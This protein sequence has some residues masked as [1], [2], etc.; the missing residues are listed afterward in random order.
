MREPQTPA[1]PPSSRRSSRTLLPDSVRRTVTD[2]NRRFLW[3]VLRATAED[4]SSFRMPVRD[5]VPAAAFDQRTIDAMAAC[6]FT[7]FELRLLDAARTVT[8]GA[9]HIQ[10]RDGNPATFEPADLEFQSLVHGALM[11]AWR[12]ADSSPLSLRLALGLPADAELL[13]NETPV[14]T[15]PE[16]ARSRELVRTRWPEHPHFWPTLVRAAWQRDAATLARVH[17][18]GVTL[19]VGALGLRDP[20]RAPPRDV[21]PR[22]RR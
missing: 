10:V 21:T 15:L 14:T 3:R 16:W 17:G 5:L 12:L 13:L 20:D 7:L 8:G 11:F 4:P 2:L 6:P 18:L 9:A 1:S 22:Q 19:L